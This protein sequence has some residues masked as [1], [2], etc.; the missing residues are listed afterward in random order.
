MGVKYKTKVDKMTKVITT[1]GKLNGK[2]VYVG[3][4][5]GEHAWLAGIHEYG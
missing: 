3:A 1:M 5:Q 4:L 2:K